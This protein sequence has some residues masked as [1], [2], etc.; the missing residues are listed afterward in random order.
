MA[1]Q[2]RRWSQVEK[3][4]RRVAATQL[5]AG[6]A[7]DARRLATQVLRRRSK[8]PSAQEV[9]RLARYLARQLPAMRILVAELQ[10]ARAQLRR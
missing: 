7:V 6:E 9:A 2:G 8:A 1:A 4:A 10:G 3:H 5:R